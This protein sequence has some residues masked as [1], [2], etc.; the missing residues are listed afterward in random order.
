MYKSSGISLA[1]T[2]LALVLL[3]GLWATFYYRSAIVDKVNDIRGENQE[4]AQQSPAP[5]P[6]F[7]TPLPV[8]TFQPTSEPA[9]SPEPTAT[10]IG[11]IAEITPGATVVATS[12][13]PLPRS[14][15]ELNIALLGGL[16]GMGTTVSYYVSLRR[17]LKKSWK[18]ID[19]VG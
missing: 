8:G 16:T 9:K 5:V 17:K 19:I 11:S 15:P 18:S 1:G 4:T 12:N 10:P 7:A 13:N 2:L 3:G 14:G 6:D